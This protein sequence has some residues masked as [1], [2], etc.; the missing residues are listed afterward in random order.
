[1]SKL[2]LELDQETGIRKLVSNSSITRPASPRPGTS[3]FEGLH[4]IEQ[5]SGGPCRSLRKHTA[6]NARPFSPAPKARMPNSAQSHSP[7]SSRH[8]CDAV[9]R[10]IVQGGSGVAL[11]INLGTGA[12]RNLYALL[13]TTLFCRP[14]RRDAFGN[15]QLQGVNELRILS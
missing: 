7:A 1:M 12:Q 9:H 13:V 15:Q 4:R 6:D 14:N 11:V 5:I 8:H 2:I 3:A 10:H